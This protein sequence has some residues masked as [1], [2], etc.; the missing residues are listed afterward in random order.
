MIG[1]TARHADIAREVGF[2]WTPE[3]LETLYLRSRVLLACREAGLRPLTGLWED[4]ADLDG[5][6]GFATRGRQ[7]GFRGMIVIHPSH[8]PVVNEVFS[9]SEEDI[10]FYRGMV[11]AYLAAARAGEGAIRYRGVHIDRAHYDKAVRWL[12]ERGVS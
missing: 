12:A 3:G 1:P 9:P 10:D 4:I 7:L 11:S 5:L 8:V 6:A 2:E